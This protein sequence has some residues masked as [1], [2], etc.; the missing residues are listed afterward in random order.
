MAGIV[1][2]GDL[3]IALTPAALKHCPKQERLLRYHSL[4]KRDV[5]ILN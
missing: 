4:V 2:D 1:L 5:H 3:L